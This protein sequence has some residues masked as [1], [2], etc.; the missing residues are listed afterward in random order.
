MIEKVSTIKVWSVGA[1]T[2]CRKTWSIHRDIIIHASFSISCVIDSINRIL[3]S[4]EIFTIRS[5]N[6]GTKVKEVFETTRMDVVDAT[7]ELFMIC[8]AIVGNA[9]FVGSVG[10]K[11]W[12]SREIVVKKSWN[13]REKVVKKSI[14]SAL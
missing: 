5:F 3:S 9:Q 8:L 7:S 1:A 13:S 12:K 11:S 10:R 14:L 6:W 4:V 2:I